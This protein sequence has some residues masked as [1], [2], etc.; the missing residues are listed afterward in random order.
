MF[1]FL[2]TTTTTI[3][4]YRTEQDLCWKYQQ[5]WKVDNLPYS[6]KRLNCSRSFYKQ[7]RQCQR[8]IFA[9]NTNESGQLTTC[10]T[11]G[12]NWIVLVHF[13]NDNDV[14]TRSLLEIPTRVDSWQPAI[15]QEATELFSFAFLT[16]VTTTTSILPYCRRG[17]DCCTYNKEECDWCWL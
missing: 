14:N 17:R 8:E 3:L 13:S 5:E 12:S 7:R 2:T 15:Q 16:T 6:R 11:A 9:G 1:V 10:H 4:P